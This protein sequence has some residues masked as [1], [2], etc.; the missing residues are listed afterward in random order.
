MQLSKKTIRYILEL[1]PGS[2]GQLNE[3]ACYIYLYIHTKKMLLYS[4]FDSLCGC[5]S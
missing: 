2:Y 5:E 4:V 3:H 1:M